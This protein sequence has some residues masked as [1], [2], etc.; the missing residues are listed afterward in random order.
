MADLIV[1]DEDVEVGDLAEDEIHSDEVDKKILEPQILLA[2]TEDP[3][4]P[5]KLTVS[6]E[7]MTNTIKE[8]LPWDHTDPKVV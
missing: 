7:S 2:L 5:P 8:K 6:W 1:E 4:L 3:Q